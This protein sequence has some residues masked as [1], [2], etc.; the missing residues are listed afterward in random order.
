[1]L[2]SA[3]TAFLDRLP[4]R[5]VRKRLN[6][7][8]MC[9]PTVETLL[10]WRNLFQRGVSGL[11]LISGFS[12]LIC[13]GPAGLVFLVSSEPNPPFPEYSSL[14]SSRQTY[15]VTTACY[16]EVMNL[17]YRVTGARHLGPLAWALFLVQQYGFVG[18]KLALYSGLVDEVDVYILLT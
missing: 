17:G 4:P 7:W 1:M 15:L 3:V 14:P 11:L 9:P 8:K 12:L 6:S 10:R 13:I 2:P 16:T 5:Y 18:D